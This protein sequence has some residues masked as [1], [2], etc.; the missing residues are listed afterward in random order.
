MHVCN[1][2]SQFFEF[3]E[4]DPEKVGNVGGS[5]TSSGVGKVKWKWLDDG[6][7]TFEWTFTDVKF[8]PD[9][10]VNVISIHQFG[11]ELEQAGLARNF[12]AEIVS[13][14]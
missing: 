10:P 5:S 12:S 7:D 8:Y 2:R 4:N 6:G 14:P 13:N 11:K 1:D 9:S 3:N